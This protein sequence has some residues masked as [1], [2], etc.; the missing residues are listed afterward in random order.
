LSDA[1]RDRSA[2][3]RSSARRTLRVGRRWRWPRRLAI[4]LV[5][6]L[7]LAAAAV[8]AAAPLGRWYVRA[9]L[10]PRVE[11]ALGR[12]VTIGR[13]NL[14]MRRVEVE[15]V[16]I[17]GKGDDKAPLVRVERVFSD[18]DWWQLVRGNARIAQVTVVGSRLRLVRRADGSDNFSDLFRRRKGRALAKRLRIGRVVLLRGDLTFDERRREIRLVAKKLQG[19][20]V[21]GGKSKIALGDVHIAL[22]LAVPRTLDFAGIELVGRFSRSR[23]SLNAV[24]VTGGRFKLRPRLELSGI[25]GTLLP[26]LKARR[27]ELDL[28]GSYGGA[29]A[30]L[31]SAKG[32]IEPLARRGRLDRGNGLGCGCDDGIRGGK[33]AG[34]GC[35][36]CRRVGGQCRR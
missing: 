8:L 36:G 16:V 25:A 35:S 26:K 9:K 12:E 15:N 13:I 31:W 10:L 18:V 21:P 22:P 30:K 4:A 14:E 11:R 17:R 5:T 2:P 28:S 24:N 20:I 7:A 29:T 19:S 23:P 34:R 1:R 3:D 32:F 6:L 33:R 27:I